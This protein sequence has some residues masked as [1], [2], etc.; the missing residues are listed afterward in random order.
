MDPNETLRLLEAVVNVG[1]WQQA[2]QAAA[3]LREWIARG[4]F[5]PKWETCPIATGYF[6][7]R[8]A[9]V[10]RDGRALDACKR[11]D[12][13]A[14]ERYDEL[15]VDEALESIVADARAAIVGADEPTAP[16]IAD[17]L[18]HESRRTLAEALNGDPNIPLAGGAF[19]VFP[20]GNERR[21]FDL[22]DY[23]VS[24]SVS[25]P[26]FILVPRR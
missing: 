22:S 5:P 7:A 24:S 1:D 19:Q 11:L 14:H 15:D 10:I 8:G 25:G 12:E 21:Y 3:D 2:D 16:E 9:D 23:V 20:R 26:S 6:R 13:Y 17:A 4:G 18:A